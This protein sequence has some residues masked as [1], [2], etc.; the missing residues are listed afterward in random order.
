MKQIRARLSAA[1]GIKLTGEMWNDPSYR[2]VV[3]LIWQ[4][5]DAVSC[6]DF[7]DTVME[8]TDGTFH[9]NAT[10][11]RTWAWGDWSNTK[12]NAVTLDFAKLATVVDDDPGRIVRLLIHEIA[13][14]WTSGAPEAATR[15]FASLHNQRGMFSNYGGSSRE[16]FAGSARSY[17]RCGS[18]SESRPCSR[19]PTSRCSS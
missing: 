11:K 9:L 17:A 6:T 8:R 2:E 3:R 1:H 15:G 14:A 4:G 19:R 12:S 16:T 18:R 7:L 5:L 10:R 13:H